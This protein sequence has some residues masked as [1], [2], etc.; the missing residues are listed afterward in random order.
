MYHSTLC[1]HDLTS[2]MLETQILSSEL[3]RFGIIFPD[4]PYDLFV[5]YPCW[6]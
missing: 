6:E 1:S 3:Q 5:N 4:L 2:G